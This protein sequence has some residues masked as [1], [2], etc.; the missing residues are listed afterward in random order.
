M[1]HPEPPSAR[2]Q[3]QGL[4]VPSR[5]QQITDLFKEV[6]ELP[7]VA[8]SQF[9]DIKCGTDNRLRSEPAQRK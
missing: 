9:L 7:P 4:V 8:R 5:Q 2:S 6:L 3:L 1:V